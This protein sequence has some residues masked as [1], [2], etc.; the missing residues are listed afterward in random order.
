MK[1]V[2]LA[3]VVLWLAAPEAVADPMD[4]DVFTT[5][6]GISTGVG[7]TFSIGTSPETAE[8]S[9][10]AFAGIANIPELYH[11][12]MS[13]W[14]VNPNGTG[15]INFET[16]AAEVEF[17][18]RTLGTANGPTLIT[19]FDDLAQVIDTITLTSSDPWQLVSFS[20]S[21]DRLEV[22][23]QAT[24][25]G[26]MNSIDDFGFSPIPESSTWALALFG[27]LACLLLRFRGYLKTMGLKTMGLKTTAWPRSCVVNTVAA[28]VA[29]GSW[30]AWADFPQIR[31]QTVSSEELV[32]PL[33]LTNAGDGSNRL[34][35]VGQ[36]GTIDII[37]GG[38]L[39]PTAF[40][41]IESKLVPE[42][43][44]F[45]ERGLLGLAF[46]PD[47][48]ATG[49][50]GEERFYVYY[51]A[52]R[53]G[54]D[55][56][57]PVNP[58]D[59]QS[60]I[61]EYRVSSPG[62]NMADPNSERILLTFDQPQFNHDG[63]QLAF[64]PDEKLYISTGDGGGGGD[65]EPGHTGGGDENPS[66]GLGNGQDRSKLL[67]KV[68]RIDVEGTNGPG[69]QYGIPADNPF[70]G[71]GGGVRE[72]IFAYGLRN[73]WRFSF[74]DG[75][76]GSG[77]LFLGDVGQ[78]DVEEVNIIE[79]GKN[80][81]WR[82]KEG[83]FDFDN[84]VTPDPVVPLQDPIAEYTR[85]GRANG[86][87]EIGVTV[88]GGYVYRGADFPELLGKYIFADWSIGFRDVNGT[89]LGL[90]ET[91]P[92]D[93]DLSVLDVEGGNPIGR[94]ITALGEDESGE[95]YLLTRT[96]LA[97]SELDPVTGKPTG[98]V[99]KIGVVPEPGSLLLLATAGL[100]LLAAAWRRGMKKG[101]G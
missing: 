24:G 95:L 6:E 13:A 90:E 4:Q 100:L 71:V 74:D 56:N 52:P 54:G 48:G 57:D 38:S 39:L 10:D 51:S 19:A 21:V 58:I 18:A 47:F 12:G 83:T 60:V 31:L 40:L 9:G 11:S 64:G 66:G 7:E 101:T 14:M 16:N 15:M 97:V 46:H 17:W 42:R 88:V 44:N 27:V 92:G 79:S 76:G 55:P 89:L 20:G 23:N 84:T 87:P 62:S 77:R 82:I 45:D 63:G 29:L 53:P 68:L 85:A 50:W 36:R 72:E 99:F 61:A 98:A 91:S 25:A 5:F 96:T 8:F 78:G 32:A 59:H 3:V 41:D 43:Q 80:Y 70:E 34:F 28:F 1:R 73:P 26:Q 37:Q 93:F 49:T 94:Y 30:Q 65:N 67:G 22:V 69:G 81:G 86:L 33:A 2:A 75:P 35:V